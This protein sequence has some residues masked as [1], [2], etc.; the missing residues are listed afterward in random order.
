M[1]LACRIRSTFLPL[2]TSRHATGSYAWRRAQVRWYC[3]RPKKRQAGVSHADGY[4][5]DG[6]GRTW[7]SDEEA[8]GDA[9]NST[10]DITFGD[11]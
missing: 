2:M 8:F 10:T 9:A 11:Q 7:I 5:E 4:L 3:F 1:G 6:R